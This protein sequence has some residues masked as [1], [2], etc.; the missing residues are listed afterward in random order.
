M[1][2]QLSDSVATTPAGVDCGSSRPGAPPRRRRPATGFRGRLLGFENREMQGFLL[3]P[4]LEG[5]PLSAFIC[6]LYIRHNPCI[7]YVAKSSVSNPVFPFVA[8]KQAIG[9]ENDQST[10]FFGNVVLHSGAPATSS[11]T[12]VQG[13]VAYDSNYMYICVATNTWKRIAASTF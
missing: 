1:H 2:R 8:Q 11:S 3:C 9:V 10:R 12:G 7:N 4:P 5:L 6:G 13:Q